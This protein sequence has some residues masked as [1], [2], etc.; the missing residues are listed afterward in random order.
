MCPD[1]LVLSPE[2]IRAGNSPLAPDFAANDF[3]IGRG[4]KQPATTVEK[5]V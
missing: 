2:F 5:A 1:F 4:R 3:G